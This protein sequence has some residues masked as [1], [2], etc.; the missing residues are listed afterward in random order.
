MYIFSPFILL[1][2]QVE[3]EDKNRCHQLLT[4]NKK[5]AWQNDRVGSDQVNQVVSQM[6]HG[7]KTSHFKWV[8]TGSGCRFQVGLGRVD[9]YFHLFFFIYKK[10][11]INN[12]YLPFGKLCNKLFDVKCII[13]NSLLISRINSI[14]FISTYSIILKLYNS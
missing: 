4:K 9:P 6:G 11:K 1:V 13:L 3:T 2:R 12:M 8:K 10:K 14:K 5:E 7:L